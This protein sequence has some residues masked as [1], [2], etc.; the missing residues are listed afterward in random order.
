MQLLKLLNIDNLTEEEIQTYKHRRTVRV[1]AF[2]NNSESE[3]QNKIA[4]INAKNRGYYELPG[5]GVEESESLEL[6]AIR[7]AKEEIG[8]DIEITG[9]IGIFKEYIKSKNLI[10]ETFCFIARVV[11]E[12]GDQTLTNKEIAEGKSVMWVD[13]QEAIRLI[14]TNPSPDLY[15]DSIVRDETFMM[16]YL[17]DTAM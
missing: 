9:E 17:E 8:C 7:E 1:I 2:D 4:F 13:I 10:N 12:K 16:K 14:R 6:G 3:T 5:G 15:P 11:G